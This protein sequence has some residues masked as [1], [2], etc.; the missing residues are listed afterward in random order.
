VIQI[1][2]SLPA[3]QLDKHYVAGMQADH[4][5][6]ILK[7]QCEATL[8]QN[9]QAKQYAQQ[10]LPVLQQHHQQTMQAA[11]A[12]GL[13]SGLEAIT[14]GAR[15]S[16][17]SSGSSG[18]SD[19]IGGSSSSSGASG[20][21]T[22]TSGSSSGSSG[23]STGTSGSSGGASGQQRKQWDERFVRQ[24]RRHVRQLE[25]FVGKLQRFI[26]HR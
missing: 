6:D 4:A 13:Q 22:G 2:A 20:Q 26:R 9:Q 16:G 15:I 1:I 14:A 21:S 24:L 10:T 11:Q 3:D 23:Q 12:L 8:G 18:R 5:R 19:T 17:D 25:R 7:Y